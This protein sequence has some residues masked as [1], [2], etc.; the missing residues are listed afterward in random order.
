M[1]FT[2]FE[3]EDERIGRAGE[4]YH[5]YLTISKEIIMG[6][7]FNETQIVLTAFV[8]G[9]VKDVFV[10]DQ[11]SKAFTVSDGSNTFRV[12]L[13]NKAAPTEEGEAVLL[14]TPHNAPQ[15]RVRVLQYQEVK[16]FEGNAYTWQTTAT[17]DFGQALIPTLAP[18]AETPVEE[19]VEAPVETPVVEEP[20]GKAKDKPEGKPEPKATEEPAPEP[21]VKLDPPSDSKPVV[22]KPTSSR[23]RSTRK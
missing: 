10:T 11:K 18:V 21:V 20:K 22:T 23:R 8:N 4:I 3:M 19:P 12:H 9:S 14:V 15:E 13:T 2:L 7:P 16:T 17:T 1:A 6:N 5:K